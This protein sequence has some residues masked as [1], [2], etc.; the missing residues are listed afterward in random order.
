MVDFEID[1]LTVVVTKNL[2]TVVVTNGIL[3]VEQVTNLLKTGFP[4]Y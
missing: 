1:D 2:I 3:S 4:L